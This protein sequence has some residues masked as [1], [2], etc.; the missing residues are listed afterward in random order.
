MTPA[1]NYLKKNKI[2]FN[3]LRYKHDAKHQ[4]YGLEASEKLGLN[5]N[6]VFKT[7]VVQLDGDELAVAI[8]PVNKT[9]NMKETARI[10]KVK[11]VAMADARQVQSTTGY[12][13]GGVSPL[14]QKK[15]LRTVIDSTAFDFSEIFVSAGRR[16]VEIE[17]DP[18]DLLRLCTGVSES[19]C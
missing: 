13:L 8:L 16:G 1:I 9:L 12:V 6:Q 5:P 4:S 17:L 7:L 3:L 14:A 10:F 2:S 15:T 18:T 11:K 19:I